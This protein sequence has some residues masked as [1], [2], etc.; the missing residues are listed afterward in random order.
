MAF[1]T[2]R[3]TTS[4]SDSSD[5]TTHVIDMPSGISIGDTILVCFIC[6]G[7][8]TVT[9]NTTV[10]GSNWS[11]FTLQGYGTSLIGNMYAKIAESTNALTLNTDNSEQGS[12]IVYCLY[13]ADTAQDGP[14][15]SGD[16]ANI[17]PAS[18]GEAPAASDNLYIVFGGADG[19]VVASVA[20]DGFTGLITETGV[21]AANSVGISSAHRTY[22]SASDLDIGAFTSDTEQ[23]VAFTNRFSYSWSG[24]DGIGFNY[25]WKIVETVS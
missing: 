19:N 1:P 16:S 18:I 7:N 13:N 24:G 5:T 6:D 17:N 14:T 23:W 22:S 15:A 8:P 12:S 25:S 3:S 2:I 4:A 9:I 20:P 11:N 10:S 21:D